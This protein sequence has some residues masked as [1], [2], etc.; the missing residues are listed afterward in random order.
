MNFR[1]QVIINTTNIISKIPF[2][3]SKA[4]TGKTHEN[5]DGKFRES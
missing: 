5:R 4:L 3:D 1:D 2:G